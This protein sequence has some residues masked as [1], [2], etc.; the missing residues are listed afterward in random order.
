MDEIVTNATKLLQ[1]AL[2]KAGVPESHGL[3]HALC[4]LS[5]TNRA[6]EESFVDDNRALACK[7]AALL[8][9]ADDKKYFP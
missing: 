7:L 1:K 6:I 5:H 8:H 4:V 2:D 9:D 3:G